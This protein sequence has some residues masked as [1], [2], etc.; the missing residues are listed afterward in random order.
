MQKDKK[1]KLKSNR[2]SKPYLPGNKKEI[3][4]IWTKSK[5]FGQRQEISCSFKIECKK[6]RFG[7]TFT[8]KIILMASVA[9]LYN[10]LFYCPQHF[11]ADTAMTLYNCNEHKL[12][13]F[14][15]KSNNI[16]NHRN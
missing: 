9:M 16:L 7:K 13:K 5:F 1:F 12:G 10:L 11:S 15:N 6:T 2:Y 3:A 14:I 4:K 8:W